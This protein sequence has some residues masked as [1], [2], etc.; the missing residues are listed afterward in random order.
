M[1]I[2][3][4]TLADLNHAV[5][6]ALTA[7]FP[8]DDPILIR[9]AYVNPSPPVPSSGQDV[10][11]FHLIPDSSPPRT[12]TF[13]ESGNPSFFRFA[14]FRLM[15]TLYGPRAETLAWSLYH[16]LF[17]DGY[18]C[19]RRILRQAGIYPVPDIPG[20]SLIWEE[21]EK[22]H[23]PRADLVIPLRIA[24]IETVTAPQPDDIQSVPDVITHKNPI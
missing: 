13:R 18:D 8:P 4:A 21:W 17:Q 19:P 22:Q 23:R 20:P 6:L 14:P 1:T 15:L 9:Q 10:L 3:S 24:V 11:Y 16:L 5:F 7:V 2:P 12:E